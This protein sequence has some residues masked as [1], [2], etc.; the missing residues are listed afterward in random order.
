MTQ[1]PSRTG[2]GSLD[3]RAKL[4]CFVLLSTWAFVFNDPTFVL[5]GLLV[6]LAL[7]A[8]S[9]CLRAVW[10]M[11]LFFVVMFVATTVMWQF[12]LEGPTP[13]GQ[14]G[15]VSLSSEGVR[16]GLA[17]ALRV[18]YLVV[19]GL[20]FGAVTIPEDL[21]YALEGF[22]VPHR[23]AF[24]VAL[25]VRLVPMYAS[26][27][28]TIGEAQEARGFDMRSRSPVAR[29][30][31]VAP[32]TIPFLMHAARTGQRMAVGLETKGYS[33]GQ[34]RTR[35]TILTLRG[36]DYLAVSTLVVVFGACVL[37]RLEGYGIAFTGRL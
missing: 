19:I 37:M 12:Y 30:R 34:P 16:F 25:T 10:G 33:V 14:V 9:G 26:M 27:A 7:A 1:T 18:I 22:K 15:P 28:H 17:A 2:L 4:A 29:V 5:V 3:P 35:L 36:R 32:L 31:R 6:S 23:V 24:V 11:R 21:Q 8:W 13:L 20:I